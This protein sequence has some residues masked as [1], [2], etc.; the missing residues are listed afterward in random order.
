MLTV[1]RSL[2]G[3][4]RGAFRGLPCHAAACGTAARTC[5][6]SS[7]LTSRKP[8]AEMPA[9]EDKAATRRR[10]KNLPS[11]M[12]ERHQWVVWKRM[13]RNGKPTK[14][15]CDPRTQRHA[16]VKRSTTWGTF[17]EAERAFVRGQFD[18]IGYVFTSHDPFTGVDLDKCR[19]E[20]SGA[21]E[22]WAQ[23]VVTR[24]DSYTEISPSGTGIHV[25]VKGKLSGRRRRN[26]RIE[27][28]DDLRFFCMTANHIS[29]TPTTVESRDGELAAL[30]ASTFPER[31]RR[32]KLRPKDTQWNATD[33]PA[34]DEELLD[35]IRKAKN[36]PTV[37]A[38][39]EG[40]WRDDYSSQS[41]AD[42]AL[43]SYLAF[44][45]D[46]DGVAIDRIFRAS[47]L[48]REKWDESRGDTTYGQLT[49][50]K[51]IS[52][53]RSSADG[54]GTA[55]TGLD[56]LHWEIQAKPVQETLSLDEIQTRL[57][58]F[59]S[60]FASSKLTEGPA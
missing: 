46:Q 9:F 31:T 52:G 56:R 58:V 27:M 33:R 38:L 10:L 13:T 18:G 28:Y 53:S 49:I 55:A 48:M 59:I 7:N 43:C 36:G 25:I 57:G 6:N 32:V 29:G 37:M 17:V 4:R 44:W 24:L 11:E 39:Y 41:E 47:G 40:M 12:V 2:H 42:L 34:S 20:R 23:E 30:Y 35:R 1:E 8:G 22:P 19:D 16:D 26:G 45:S 50:R 60:K 5:A 14:V 21:L 54:G 51:A 3:G 15:P